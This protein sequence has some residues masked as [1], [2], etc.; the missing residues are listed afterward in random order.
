MST[1]AGNR[2]DIRQWDPRILNAE[3]LPLATDSCEQSTQQHTQTAYFKIV[4]T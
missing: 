4:C 3:K 1:P 2:R